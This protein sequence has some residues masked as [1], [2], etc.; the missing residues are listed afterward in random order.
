[1]LIFAV[2]M[3]YNGKPH[4]EAKTMM[5][6]RL[7]LAS[8][9]C[10]A[11]VAPI[12]AQAI[13][14]YGRVVGGLRPQQDSATPKAHN[15][16]SLKPNGKGSIGGVGDLGVQSIKGQLFV[17]SNKAL[18]YSRQDDE[19]ERVAELSLGDPLTAL[20]RAT[21]GNLDWYMVRT[22]T[23]I[24]GWIKSTDVRESPGKVP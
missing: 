11:F 20:I 19:T 3:V 24:V 17:A 13:G 9:L 23:G 4:M 12:F 14:E 18:L 10:F 5:Y 8:F 7:V 21:G 15:G 22:A 1:V 2:L 6:K 16:G